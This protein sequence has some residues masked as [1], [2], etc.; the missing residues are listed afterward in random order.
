MSSENFILNAENIL[1][2]V[3]KILNTKSDRQTALRLDV[4]PQTFAN[5]KSRDSLPWER[6]YRL[7]IEEGINFDWLVT[8][9]GPIRSED[10]ESLFARVPKHKA[11]L[12]GGGGSWAFSDAGEVDYHVAF[13][14]D[15]LSRIA[16]VNR[17]VALEV[18][19]DSMSPSIGNRDLV[20]V[21]T[22]K[23]R[24]SEVL[25]G[26]IYAFS[27]DT[28]GGEALLKVKRLFLEPGSLLVRSDNVSEGHRDYSITD[29]SSVVIIGRV[30][31]VGKEL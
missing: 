5:W 19:G 26:K 29:L 7:A 24:I 8:G 30:V 21:D 23:N 20:L 11:R 25:S 3:A 12:S 4:K 27:D 15:W 28:V 1:D 6:L 22:S 17:L 10:Q 16:P 18:E 2:R 13:R 14:R 9:E 31:W